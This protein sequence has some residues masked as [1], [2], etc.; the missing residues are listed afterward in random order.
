[1]LYK[2]KWPLLIFL[3]P[4]LLFMMVFLYVPFLENIKNSFYN[5]TA[6]VKMPGTDLSLIHI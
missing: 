6:V 3:V 4:G 5:M 2:K 1:M